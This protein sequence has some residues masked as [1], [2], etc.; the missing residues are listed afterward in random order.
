MRALAGGVTEIDL[1]GEVGMWGVTAA[2]FREALA[3]VNTSDIVLN[4][5]S[6][7]GDVF[8]GVAIYN[9]LVGHAARVEVRVT[10]LA[11]SAASLIAM[12][13]DEIKISSNAFFMIHNAWSVAVGDKRAMAARAKFLEKVDGE[14][15]KT[16]ASRTGADVGDIA[17]LMDAETWMTA[18]ESVDAGFADAITDEDDSEEAAAAFDLSDFKNVPRALKPSRRSAKA[19][20]D[21]PPRPAENLSPLLA[22]IAALTAKMAA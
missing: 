12:A 20:T 14:L 5:N 2:A 1:Y 8:D 6:P 22:D 13:G 4:I 15:A 9:D 16:Y 19:K 21:A 18:D 11:A 3:N 17:S 7:G 10:G